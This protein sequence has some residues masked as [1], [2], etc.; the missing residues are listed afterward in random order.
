[1]LM[2]FFFNKPVGNVQWHLMF[3]GGNMPVGNLVIEN[4]E[5]HFFHLTNMTNGFKISK[6]TLADGAFVSSLELPS[7]LTTFQTSY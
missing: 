3:T 7:S 1:M 2:V 5:T 4:T 6:H